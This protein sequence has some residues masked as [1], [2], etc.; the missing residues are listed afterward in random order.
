MKC[1]RSNN[2]HSNA[3]QAIL[4]SCKILPPTAQSVKELRSSHLTGAPSVTTF[5]DC[6]SVGVTY[7]NQNTNTTIAKHQVSISCTPNDDNGGDDSF[8]SRCCTSLAALFTTSR[9]T[10]ASAMFIIIITIII[11]IIRWKSQR[12]AKKE[13]SVRKL[14][15]ISARSSCGFVVVFQAH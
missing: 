7:I 5:M 9:A 15:R 13:N 6:D 10:S 3:T 8:V 1:V 11:V 14:R 2:V 12:L 4:C